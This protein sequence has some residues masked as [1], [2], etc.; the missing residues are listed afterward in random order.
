MYHQR[1]EN[2]AKALRRDE[3]RLDPAGLS[4]TI[5][6]RLRSVAPAFPSPPSGLPPEI[7][8]L[9]DFGVP[10]IVLQQGVRLARR[11]GVFADEALLAEGLVD[12]EVF[13]RALAKRLGQPFLTTEFEIE[14]G[15]DFHSCARR[16]YA[17]IAGDGGQPTWVCAPQ[18]AAVAPAD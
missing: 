10:R 9:L 16:G 11:Q 6:L 14:P 7:A 17:R 12:Q 13:Y 15:A 2:F 1:A 5:A 3:K 18:G 8:F 4:T